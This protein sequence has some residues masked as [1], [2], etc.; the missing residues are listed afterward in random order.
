ME[1]TP[2]AS[3]CLHTPPLIG[4][5]YNVKIVK[6]AKNNY[7]IWCQQVIVILR[8]S[9]LI[10][11]VDGTFKAP[12]SIPNANGELAKNSQELNYEDSV[13]V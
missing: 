2:K 1:I 8:A 4:N 12:S 13:H 3:N 7:A 9:K 11:F 6:L 10:G 5:I